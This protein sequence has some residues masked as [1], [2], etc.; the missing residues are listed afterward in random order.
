MDRHRYSI[1][2]EMAVLSHTELEITELPL[3]VWTQVY[4]EQTMET[5]LHGSEKIPPLIT[6][7]KEYH[8]DTTVRF[9]VTLAEDKMLQAENEGLH[10]VFKLQS[11]HTLTS[12]VLYDSKG[13]LRTYDCVE[14][15]LKEFFTVRLEFY[16]KRKDYLAGVLQAESKRL[17][18]QA[19]FICEK[20]DNV[21]IVEN[22]KVKLFTILRI[23]RLLKTIC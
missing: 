9:L 10:K 20:C 4:K 1:S 21:L 15:I 6:D 13:C 19:R 17:S 16:G 8:T 5:L 11:T 7:F 2:G 22:K 12:M 23:I 18:N 14:D 3:R